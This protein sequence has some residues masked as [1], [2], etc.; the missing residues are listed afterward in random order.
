MAYSD[1]LVGLC[2]TVLGKAPILFSVFKQYGSEIILDEPIAD[3]F[4]VKDLI[5]HSHCL[6]NLRCPSAHLKHIKVSVF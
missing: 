6:A 2:Y 1:I 5:L 3:I 4:R